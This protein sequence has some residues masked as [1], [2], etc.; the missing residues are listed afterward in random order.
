MA[1]IERIETDNSAPAIASEPEAT[2]VV[3]RIVQLVVGIIEGLL[4][5]RLVFRLL[6]ANPNT[7]FVQFV[8]SIT[9]P[10]VAPFAGIFRTP[11]VQGNVAAATIDTSTI[12]AMIVYALIGWIIIKVATLNRRNQE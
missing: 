5:L 6:G 4:A 1:R 11:S 2:S 9:D 3:S 7:G 12:V 10:L 8:Y